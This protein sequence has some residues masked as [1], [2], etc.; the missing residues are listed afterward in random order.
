MRPILGTLAVAGELHDP[1]SVALAEVAEP[2]ATPAPGSSPPE[3]RVAPVTPGAGPVVA[4][5]C[6]NISSSDATL[7]LPNSRPPL[8]AG[9]AGAAPAAAAAAAAGDECGSDREE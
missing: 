2:P 6:Q 5:E 1:P 9:G 8:V 4:R 7:P 3:P